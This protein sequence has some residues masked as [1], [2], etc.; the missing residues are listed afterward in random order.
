MHANRNNSG[1]PTHKVFTN[2]NNI[3]SS[4]S[5]LLKNRSIN[6]IKSN[7]K[8]IDI[9]QRVVW[10]LSSLCSMGWILILDMEHILHIILVNMESLLLGLI[11]V[12]LADRREEKAMLIIWGRIL[13]T[14]KNLFSLL[15]LF[16]KMC[17]DLLWGCQWVVWLHTIW[18]YRIQNYSMVLF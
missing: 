15:L 2:F 5:K 1:N 6:Y 18:L 3:H 9:M 14:V 12:D 17:L 13:K 4:I 8:L 10:R 16:M 11:I 7:F